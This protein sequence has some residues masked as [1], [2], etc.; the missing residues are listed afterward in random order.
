MNDADKAFL[1][2]IN[3]QPDVPSP[4]P[5]LER[6]R[7]R[8]RTKTQGLEGSQDKA[9]A[10]EARDVNLSFYQIAFTTGMV[11]YD[12]EREPDVHVDVNVLPDTA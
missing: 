6:K 2:Y 11:V 9:K 8:P 4:G 3:N 12:I 1:E 5:T 7:R 10:K